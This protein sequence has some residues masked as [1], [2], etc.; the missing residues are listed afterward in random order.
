MGKLTKRVENE[1]A[2]LFNHIFAYQR[3]IGDHSMNAT[4]DY[5][6]DMRW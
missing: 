4:Y 6:T 2:Y 5:T 3:E 1:N